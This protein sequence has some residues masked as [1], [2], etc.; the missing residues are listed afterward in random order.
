MLLIPS[1]PILKPSSSFSLF[2]KGPKSFTW[3][4][5]SCHIVLQPLQLQI[6]FSSSSLTQ[7]LLS[8]GRV[9]SQMLFH[10]LDSSCWFL[11]VWLT[12]LYPA[13]VHVNDTLSV[14]LRL[15]STLTSLVVSL[16]GWTTM[17]VHQVDLPSRICYAAAKGTVDWMPS[18][19]A[20]RACP[21]FLAK[22]TFFQGSSN[23]MTGHIG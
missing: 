17:E 12:L 19:T 4:T 18:F 9:P 15:N 2:L 13:H 22:A 10:I 23:L 21:S 5:R 11:F 1:S 7:V 6:L 16:H 3:F 14:K 8:L 20:F